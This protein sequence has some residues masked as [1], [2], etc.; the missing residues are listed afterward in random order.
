[1][2]IIIIVAIVLKS[3]NNGYSCKL[4][5]SKFYVIYPRLVIKKSAAFF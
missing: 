1:M 4:H 2:I 3:Q 5:L